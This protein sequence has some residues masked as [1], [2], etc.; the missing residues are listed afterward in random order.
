MSGEERSFY[1]FRGWTLLKG[2]FP[3]NAAIDFCFN[4]CGLEGG[5]GVRGRR[6]VVSPKGVTPNAGAIKKNQCGVSNQVSTHLSALARCPFSLPGT[7]MIC[8]RLLSLFCHRP[9][10]IILLHP[11]ICLSRVTSR[12]KS[13]YH[14]SPTSYSTTPTGQPMSWLGRWGAWSANQ[15][16]L[17]FHPLTFSSMLIINPT[18]SCTSCLPPSQIN[19]S[20]SSPPPSLLPPPAS[21]SSFPI[22]YAPLC[23]SLLPLLCSSCSKVI[24]VK[25][26]DDEEYEKNKN[27]FLELGEPRMVDMSLQKGAVPNPSSLTLAPSP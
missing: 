4:R 19:L 8:T 23:P 22:F 2:Y 1:S 24:H 11:S 25:I 18:Y 10:L 5:G 3:L 16:E 27:F 17:T 6:T 26:I 20:S 14:D 13:C 15:C 21:S 7:L 12:D 9:P